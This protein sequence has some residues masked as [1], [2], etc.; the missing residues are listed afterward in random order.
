MAH[1]RYL[2]PRIQQLKRRAGQGSGETHSETVRRWIEQRGQS[3][4][5]S[6]KKVDRQSDTSRKYRQRG[7][8][9]SLVGYTNAGK[10]TLMRGLSGE[11]VLVQNQLFATLTNTTRRVHVKSYRPIL[12][13]DTVGFINRLPHHLFACFRATLQEAIDAD[14]LLHVVDASH[15]QYEMQMAT[16]NEVLTDLKIVDKPTLTVYNKM[17]LADPDRQ[18][19]ISQY[20]SADP[21]ALSISALDPEGQDTLKNQLRDYLADQAI[22]LDLNVPQSEGK[23]LAQLYK[24]GEILN[25][26]YEGNGAHL[27]VRLNPNHAERLQLK[28]FSLA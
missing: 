8:K 19:D 26:E 28:R 21:N 2:R 20:C 14:L 25:Q 3:L 24:H 4:H 9:V 6:L 16:V 7:F 22:T 15:P 11:D 18:I 5:T 1:L 17:D 23:L 13:T 27:R 12:L 10:S